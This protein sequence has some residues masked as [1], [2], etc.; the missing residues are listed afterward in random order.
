MNNP[1][2]DLAVAVLLAALAYLFIVFVML[3]GGPH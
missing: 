1:L 2:Q 3:E